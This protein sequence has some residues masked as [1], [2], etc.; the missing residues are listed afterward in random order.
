MNSL[1][2][3]KNR[4]LEETSSI[5]CLDRLSISRHPQRPKALDFIRSITTDFEEVHGDRLYGDDP[6]I[7]TGF[8]YID[9]I[10][11][12]IVAQEKGADTESRIYRN[13]GMAHPEG[14]RKALKAMKL[15]EKFNIPI[16]TLV[17]TPGAF[18]CLEA[19]ERGQGWAIAQ[20]LKEMSL[21][22][23]PIIAVVIGEGCSGGALGI[24]VC[25]HLVM[26]E[27][28]YYS[29][30]APEGCASILWKDSQKKDLAAKALKLHPENLVELDIVD[31]I[32]KEPSGGAH[33]DPTQTFLDVKKVISYNLEK[34]LKI[35]KKQLLLDRFQKYRKI[36]K[37]L[38]V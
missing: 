4:P 13:F 25:D 14:Y 32:I 20:N 7:I 5:S 31:E 24:G 33:H 15:A 19:E 34:L 1:K 38:E 18:P 36:G 26:L 30:I 12:L 17:D 8:C 16:V 28:A 2:E 6:S 11:A 35:S 10:K 37:Y 27:H 9:E 3:Q 21:L 29:V 23:V 22:E